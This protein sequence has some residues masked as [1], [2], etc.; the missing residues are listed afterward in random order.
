MI[1]QPI[2]NIQA[3]LI[4]RTVPYNRQFEVS[5]DGYAEI[6]LRSKVN[7]EVKHLL[8]ICKSLIPHLDAISMLHDDIEILSGFNGDQD[9]KEFKIYHSDDAH[10]L[11]LHGV[12]WAI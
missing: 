7:K 1:K 3:E 10:H 11:F 5:P 4:E 6:T 9:E 2:T 8:L 12:L